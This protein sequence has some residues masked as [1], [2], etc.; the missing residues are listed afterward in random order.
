MFSVAT[1]PRTSS[2]PRLPVVRTPGAPVAGVGRGAAIRLT[3][4]EGRR[5]TGSRVVVYMTSREGRRVAFVCGRRVGGA[6]MRNRARRIMREAVRVLGPRIRGEMH[7]VL[8]AQPAIRGARMHEV[9]AEVGAL[10]GGAGVLA[11]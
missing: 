1:T 8:V 9:L 7:L 4:R 10:L 6:V 3:L 11:R 5:L 2:V